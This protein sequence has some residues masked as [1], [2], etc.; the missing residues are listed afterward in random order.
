MITVPFLIKCII[1]GLAVC[2]LFY[3][4]ESAASGDED[5]DNFFN[6]KP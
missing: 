6:N 5:Y 2:G 1:T 3:V 4:I